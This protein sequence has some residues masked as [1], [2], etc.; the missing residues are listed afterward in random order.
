MKGSV[1][2]VLLSRIFHVVSGF[3]LHFMLYCGNFDCFSDDVGFYSYVTW[4]AQINLI[5]ERVIK[6]KR[7]L[8]LFLVEFQPFWICVWWHHKDDEANSSNQ[9]FWDLAGEFVTRVG[10]GSTFFNSYMHQRNIKEIYV[11]WGFYVFTARRGRRR[12]K[13]RYAGKSRCYCMSMLKA[14]SLTL[15]H[16]NHA[17]P[18]FIT[19][20][21]CV[22]Q[23]QVL[24]FENI[25]TKTN[26][27]R[28]KSKQNLGTLSL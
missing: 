15:S 3:P 9:I 28:K 12:Q 20:P 11:G 10:I 21:C 26:L 2:N 24:Y 1:V 18:S 4:I 16:S 27:W 14:R 8:T 5:F 19:T 7:T 23:R 22:G 13:V 17:D 25:F 6:G